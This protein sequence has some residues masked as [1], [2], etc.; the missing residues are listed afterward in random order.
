M[1]FWAS[2]GRRRGIDR[3]EQLF[4]QDEGHPHTT[5]D[6]IA[7][8]RADF[9]LCGYLKD[10]V[11]ENNPQTIGELKAAITAKIRDF[12]KE[13]CVRVIDNFARRMQVCLQHR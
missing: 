6:S 8:L 7:W 5:N 2:L 13:E 11:Y 3:D 1:K 12:P 9:Y 10:N 4:Q